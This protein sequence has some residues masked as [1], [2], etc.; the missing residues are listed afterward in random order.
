MATQEVD[1]FKA[2]A[3]PVID[4]EM[5]AFLEEQSNIVPPPQVN[6]LST[7]GK[8]F[9]M[10]LDGE[11]KPLMRKDSD[12]D[13]IPVS[14]FKAVILDWAQKRG[15]SFYD[16]PYDPK[17]PQMP[18][19]WSDDCD[20]P[21]V[22]VKKPQAKKCEGCPQSVKGS[23]QSE[24]G[25]DMTACQQYRLISLVPAT[26]L[27]QFPPLR[28]K[29]SITADY[30][31][32]K[33][34]HEDSGW[35]AYGNYMRYLRAKGVAHTAKV[36]TKIKFDPSVTWPKLLFAASAFMD[37]DQLK[38][39]KALLGSDEVKAQVSGAFSPNGKDGKTLPAPDEPDGPA[40][41][42]AKDE[43][44]TAAEIAQA[45]AE[46]AAQKAAAAKPAETAEQIEARELA[47]FKATKA[48]AKAEAEA[49]AEAARIAARP[50]ETEEEKELREFREMKAAKAAANGAAP[51]AKAAPASD[52]DGEGEIILPN[53][54]NAK[55][56]AAKPAG[57]AT[58]KAA[59]AAKQGVVVAAAGKT[60]AAPKPAGAA[61]GKSALDGLLKEWGDE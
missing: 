14:V 47:E 20:T 59:T 46:K 53:V 39:V 43:D 26:G 42:A 3:M 19:C 56:D 9:T 4:A 23:R 57:G 29:L 11:T 5:D 28:M 27:G 61:G 8:Q 35:F 49:A 44:D 7:S 24:K 25:Q 33:G 36:V 6:S 12:G 31:G 50:K 1:I 51:V 18:E 45:K 22:H 30:D 17:K 55:A 10:T 38:A 40:I 52:D 32:K 15:R 34:E 16:G 21:S 37:N 60:T 58:A 48:K 13:E 54:A 41:G 2:G